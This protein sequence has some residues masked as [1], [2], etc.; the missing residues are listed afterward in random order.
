MTAGLVTAG[1]GPG[2][3]VG[4]RSTSAHDRGLSPGPRTLSLRLPH[5]RLVAGGAPGG[6]ARSATREPVSRE[7]WTTRDAQGKVVSSTDVRRT[8]G[9]GG[10]LWVLLGAFVLVGP[11]T[12][13]GDGQ[14]PV[15]VAVVMYAIEALVAV[16]ALIG[17]VQRRRAGRGEPR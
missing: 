8:S 7:T 4:A 10:C 17:Y 2:A 5:A 11:A 6:R 9:C 15:A 13:A 16:A 3:G 14:I 12:W 1:R